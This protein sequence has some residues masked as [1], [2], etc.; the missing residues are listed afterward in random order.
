MSSPAQVVLPQAAASAPEQ[1]APERELAVLLVEALNL[2]VLPAEI[3]PNA[4]LYGEGLGLDSIDILEVALE[5]SRRY[6]F[7]LRSDDANNPQIFRSLR[8]LASHVA[9]HRTL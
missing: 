4:P 7:Q 2:E 9:Q 3:D 5:V 8:S 6:G 1:S